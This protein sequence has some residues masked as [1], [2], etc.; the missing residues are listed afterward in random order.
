MLEINFLQW[1]NQWQAKIDHLSNNLLLH[2]FQPLYKLTLIYQL[3]Y[4][5]VLL[6]NHRMEDNLEVH[7]EEICMEDHH[8]IHML[9]LTNGQHLTHACLYDHGINNLY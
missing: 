6:I 5:E 8:L 1:F 7:L 4:L 3:M 9:D 2:Q